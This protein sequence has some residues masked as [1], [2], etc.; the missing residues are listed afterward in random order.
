M[1]PERTLLRAA[2]LAF[3]R[4]WNDSG[5]AVTEGKAW[6]KSGRMR[7]AHQRAVRRHRIRAYA[8]L[9]DQLGVAKDLC[10]FG[11]FDEATLRRVLALCQSADPAGVRKYRPETASGALSERRGTARRADSQ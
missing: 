7:K 9:A 4:L 6:I 2:H 8:W 10:H 5:G 11:R 3:D 1:T